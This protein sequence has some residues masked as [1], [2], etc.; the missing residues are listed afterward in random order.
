[1]ISINVRRPHKG[2]FGVLFDEENCFGGSPFA[3]LF[4]DT[5]PTDPHPN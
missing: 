1:M 4:R 2:Y 5:A 3:F